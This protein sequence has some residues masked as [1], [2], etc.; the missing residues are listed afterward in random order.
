MIVVVNTARK[1][2]NRKVQLVAAFLNFEFFRTYSRKKLTAVAP[3]S[4]NSA[5][6]SE[7]SKTQ[8]AAISTTS[9]ATTPSP[10]CLSL[11]PPNR[12]TLVGMR[13]LLLLLGRLK[14]VCI[15]IEF[16][17]TVFP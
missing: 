17:G 11:I 14:R 7:K 3:V 13:G 9:V 5:V 8:G 16:F 1:R 6:I 4:Q 15:I 12:S 10:N 2:F